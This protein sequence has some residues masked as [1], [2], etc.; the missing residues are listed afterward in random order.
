MGRYYVKNI[1]ECSPWS[2]TTGSVDGV[3]QN[4]V[5]NHR[6]KNVKMYS[7]C[8]IMRPIDSKNSFIKLNAEEPLKFKTGFSVYKLDKPEVVASGALTDTDFAAYA[9]GTSEELIAKVI[10]TQTMK[11][12][13]MMLAAA[14]YLSLAVLF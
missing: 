10:Y 12:G 14:S 11:Q 6:E 4:L 5:H 3:V 2:F 13:A 8:G 9:Q 7:R 1:K